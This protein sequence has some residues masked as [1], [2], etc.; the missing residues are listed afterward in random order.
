MASAGASGA[1]RG[2]RAP[3]PRPLRHG[4]SP[5]PDAGRRPAGPLPLLP[6][7]N[8]WN[9]DVTQAPVDPASAAFIHFIGVDAGN[10]PRLRRRRRARRRRSTACPYSTVPGNQPLVPVDFDYADESDPG[11]PGRP[12]GYPIPEEAKTQPKWIE[13]GYPGAADAG[14]RPPP[15]DRRP[16]PPAA[17]RAL[18]PALGRQP[19]WTGGSGAVWPLDANR[20]RPEG[21][22]SADA[23]GLAILPGLVRY[24]EAY[25]TEP[26]RHA[27][28]VT[29]RATNGYVFPASHAAGS[30]TGALPMGARLRLKSAQGHLGLSRTAAADLPGDEDLRAHR[31][32]QRQRHVR[33]GHLRHTLGQRRAEPGLRRPEGLRLR[34]R[35]PRLAAR[36][37]ASAPSGPRALRRE[38]DDALPQPGALR[39]PRRVDRLRRSPGRRPRLS[40][41]HRLRPLL[42]LHAN[43]TSRC[44]SR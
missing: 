4:G 6:A 7:D 30:T 24:D 42:V 11:A 39:R 13:G 26:I 43:R 40:A 28:R 8:W 20:R 2:A 3:L 41:H 37:R 10:A 16:R 35:P 34:G 22:T 25:G 17:L 12:A 23:A 29:V 19:T 5:G 31:R 15:A 18:R 27:F 38:C 36:G 9:V 21:W 14:R 44:W 32:G 33:L 1:P